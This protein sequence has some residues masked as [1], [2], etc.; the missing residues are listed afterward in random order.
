MIAA[1]PQIFKIPA[2]IQPIRFTRRYS[3]VFSKPFLCSRK[4]CL[5]W[6]FLHLV[7]VW[8]KVLKLLDYLV[9]VKRLL[10][11]TANKSNKWLIIGTF[12]IVRLV[13]WRFGKLPVQSETNG[14]G[15]INLITV[16][17][18]PYIWI[19]VTPHSY[20]YLN[21]EYSPSDA[22]RPASAGAEACRFPSCLSSRRSRLGI[23]TRSCA[24]LFGHMESWIVCST[25]CTLFKLGRWRCF[26]PPP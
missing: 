20:Y 12:V 19:Q 11:S 17:Y 23:W 24:G 7:S 15:R 4:L 18:N 9:I 14:P 8:I 26:H 25:T 1:Y 6:S 2:Y 10:T 5:C 22:S 16:L 13:A 21:L 3:I